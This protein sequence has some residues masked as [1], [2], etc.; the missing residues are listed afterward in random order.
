MI[1]LVS[2]D[3]TNYTFNHDVC[4]PLTCLIFICNVAHSLKLVQD[5]GQAEDIWSAHLNASDVI[6]SVSEE[7]FW[8]ER[9]LAIVKQTPKNT[10]IDYKLPNMDVL[11]RRVLKLGDSAHSFLPS[12]TN[13]ATQAMEDGIC[14][15]A[16]LKMAGKN[17]VALATRVHTKLR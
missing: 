14:I 3:I 4:S 17:N 10:M 9:V 16:C 7:M 5:K 8:D 6:D 1:I 11:W 12:S 2:R 15:A 13:G